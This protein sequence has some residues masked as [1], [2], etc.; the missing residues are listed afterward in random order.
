MD[1][2]SFT[3]HCAHGFNEQVYNFSIYLTFALH[4]LYSMNIA[5]GKT[6]FSV[7]VVVRNDLWNCKV[8]ETEYKTIQKKSIEVQSELNV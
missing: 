1:F 2:F 6:V 5:F 7:Y 8:N 3:E 4:L